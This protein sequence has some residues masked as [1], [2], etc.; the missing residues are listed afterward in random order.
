[1][2]GLLA[3]SF[4]AAAQAAAPAPQDALVRAIDRVVERPVFASA[5]WGIEVRSLR[6][7]RVLY[8][9]NAEKNLRPASTLKLVVSA[10]ALDAFG[11]DARWRTTV[12]TAGRLDGHGRLLGDVYLVGRGDPALS[13]RF[14]PGRPAA[15]F[16]EMADALRAAGVQRIEGRVVG[17]EGAFSGERRGSDWGWEDLV[18]WYGAEVSALS[19]NENAVDLRLLPGERPGDPAVLEASPLTAYCSVVSTVTTTAAGV[20]AELKLERDLGTSRIRLSG[21]LPVGGSWEGRPALE[22]PAR[23]ATTVFAEVLERRGIR[24]TGSVATT[25]DPLPAGTRVLAAHDSPPLAELVKV[26][27]KESQNLYTEI[28]LRLVGQKLRGEG[29]VVAGHDVVREFL[30]RVGVAAESWGL[31]DGS[32]L[33]RT[34]VV[35]AHGLAELLVAMDRHPQASAFRDSLPVMGVD[36]TLEDRMRGSPVEGRVLAK[37]GTL[38]LGNALAGY[39]T[40][41]SGERV[42]FAVIVNNHTVPSREAVAAIDEI[43]RAL[44]SR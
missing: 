22:D 34:D 17:H 39:A 25:S 9:R 6:T 4:L 32:G 3:A 12:E 7:G 20:K 28:L 19:F 5:L 29:S 31:Q 21:T 11:A 27:N 1:M 44:V 38:R 26:A 37:T 16:E 13:S 8:A 35:D 10:A 18:W 14:T 43:V 33:S 36:G 40:P 2:T 41:V 24:V 23:Y 15:A 30:K 42:A